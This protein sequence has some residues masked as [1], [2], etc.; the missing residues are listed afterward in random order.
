MLFLDYSRFICVNKCTGF[1]SL[2]IQCQQKTVFLTKNYMYV[3]VSQA[4]RP[5][6]FGAAYYG[7]NGPAAVQQQRCEQLPDPVVQGLRNALC[8]AISEIKSLKEENT[9][10]KEQIALL[11]NR[12]VEVSQLQ[13]QLKQKDDLLQ[14]A[15]KKRRARTRAHI[16]TLG[17]LGQLEKEH[18]LREEQWKSTCDA[19]AVSI[20]SKDLQLQVRF[21][22]RTMTCWIITAG[23]RLVQNQLCMCAVKNILFFSFQKLTSN[24]KEQEQLEKKKEDEEKNMTE[25]EEKKSKK[26][27]EEKTMKEEEENE[28]KRKAES[29]KMEREEREKVKK[30]GK[31]KIEKEKKETMPKHGKEKMQNKENEKVEKETKRSEEEE[32]NEKKLKTAKKKR[33]KKKK[34][35][36]AQ[37]GGGNFCWSD[38]GQTT[39]EYP[40]S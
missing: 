20:V 13:E 4:C 31:G 11:E 16:E 5:A 18:K 38:S 32:M 28:K 24:T 15:V 26:E 35:R 2:C 1:D 14:R 8:T 10:L 12:Q 7:P 40:S 39:A 27:Q 22:F 33:G 29:E 37:L 36:G 21:Y 19:L 17:L 23:F 9:A 3:S 6:Q 30:E 25:E 34:N